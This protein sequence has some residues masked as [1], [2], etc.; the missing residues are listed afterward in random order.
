MNY[1]NTLTYN[2][3]E[4]PSANLTNQLFL[5]CSNE[6]IQLTARGGNVNY[7]D[8]MRDSDS[9]AYRNNKELFGFAFKPFG[10]NTKL[11]FTTKCDYA[12]LLNGGS[13]AVNVEGWYYDKDNSTY[14]DSDDY[15]NLGLVDSHD[16]FNQLVDDDI[17]VY[18][19]SYYYANLR[20]GDY[21][22]YDFNMVQQNVTYS[23]V[24]LSYYAHYLELDNNAE[25]D[26]AITLKLGSNYSKLYDD[27]Y[28]A[29]YNN[30][31]NTGYNTGYDIGFI[32]GQGTNT[33]VETAHAFDY[34]S[35]A[36]N[37]VAGILSI[38]VLPH[39]TLG[40]C[41]SIPLVFVLIM[42]IFKL[43]RK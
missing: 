43:V 24:H 20:A 38:E 37:S 4:L 23:T 19:N 13:Y 32:A 28:N 10:G 26:Y 11:F 42:T 31:Y 2:D 22:L 35:T 12:F 41:F 8:L 14:Y 6:V 15:I 40:T 29:G 16:Y 21:C 30:G 18:S 5:I 25:E 9:Y 36:F 3:L 39:I 7:Y 34:I 33:N 27:G 17:Y 1:T